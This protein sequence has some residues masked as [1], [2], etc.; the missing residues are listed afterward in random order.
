VL[1]QLD[2]KTSTARA[3]LGTL[4]SSATVEQ[5]GDGYV[6]VDPLFAGWIAGL[7]EPAGDEPPYKEPG[8]QGVRKALSRTRTADPL[9]TI[10]RA[11]ACT[12]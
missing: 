5:Q 4:V 7:R 12:T 8:E 1:E 2:L 3:S 6:V 10:P 9:L 11:R